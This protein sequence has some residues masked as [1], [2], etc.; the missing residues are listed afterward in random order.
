MKFL[1]CDIETT[2]LETS[3]AAPFQIAFIFVYSGKENGKSIK[4]ESNRVFYLNPFDI[5]GIELSEE[6]TKVHGYTKEMIEAFEP[7]SVVVPKINE[8]LRF[9]MDYRSAE[10]MYFCGYNSKK[11]D[12][13]HMVELFRKSGFDFEKYFYKQQLDVFDQVKKA[14]EMRILPYLENRKL[15][16]VAKFLGV[17][18]E[19][20]HDALGD[21]TATREVA[22]A[23]SN[24]GVSLF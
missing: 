1:W 11:F 18:L 5:E 6:S 15:V 2:G 4:D 8:A 21:I 14:G 17:S 12:Y 19:N 16:T 23:L 24:K 10:Q 22:K 13:D 7:S 9:Y 20:A 3:N